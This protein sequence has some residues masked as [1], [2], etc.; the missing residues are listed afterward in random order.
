M[1]LNYN[2]WKIKFSSLSSSS[3]FLS[4]SLVALDKHPIFTKYF[5]YQTFQPAG[6]VRK[7]SEAFSSSTRALSGCH[8]SVILF[9]ASV[10]GFKMRVFSLPLGPQG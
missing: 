7:A 3:L 1:N 2:P 9:E 8:G 6:K 10:A 4:L 5:L